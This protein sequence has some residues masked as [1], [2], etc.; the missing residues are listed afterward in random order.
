M[1]ED[2]ILDW[3]SLV[4][5]WAHVIVGIAWIGSSFYFMWLDSHLEEPVS[6]DDEVE[7][8]LWMVHSGGFY[9]VDKIMV[10]PRT[11]PKTLHWFKWEAWWTGVTGVLLLAVVYYLG[12]QSFLIDPNISNIT[13]TQAI[14]VGVGTLIFGWVLYDALYNLSWAQTNGN[15][16]AILSFLGLCGIIFGLCEFLSPRAA[17]I[18]TG[19]LVGLVMVVNVWRRV[20][21]AQQKL[22]DARLAG[23]IPDPILAQIAKQRSVHNNYLTLPVVFIMIS[24]HYPATFGHQQNWAVLIGL[25]VIGALVRHWFNLRNSG[26]PSLWPLILSG[27]FMFALATWVSLPKMTSSNKMKITRQVG[28]DEVSRII[29]VRCSVCHASKPSFSGF[30][31]PPK[32][33]KFESARQIKKYASQIWKTAVATNTMP[34]GNVT[35]MTEKER[36]IIG[37]WI[38][39]GFNDQK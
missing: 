31:S 32:N 39:Q 10:A 36:K 4:L 13:K 22:I 6:P 14:W 2:I 5:R 33:I 37:R 15:A 12:S 7:G 11:L 9:R 28:L 23:E 8:Q 24:S 38:E 21:P 30:D 19:A 25:F 17:Y 16:A 18:H 35:K 27:V 1:F 26:F 20:L 3:L 29:S 34:L